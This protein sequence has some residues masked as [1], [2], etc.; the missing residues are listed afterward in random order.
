MTTTQFWLNVSTSFTAS[1]I[2]LFV[3]LIL[4]KPKILISPNIC[5]G[6]LNDSD[7]NEY[8]FIKIINYSLF[9][10]FDVKAELIQNETYTS[11]KKQLNTRNTSLSL[12][13]GQVSHIPGY[14]PSWLRKNAPYAIRVRTIDALE[15]ILNDDH[16]SVII[17]VSLRHGLTGLAKVKTRE[18][19]DISH[20]KKGRFKYGLTFGVLN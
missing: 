11:E 8:Y 14:R 16:K 9:N 1:F 10:A 19:S 7:P 4:F 3:L 6:K 17:K 2:F 20:L 18:Y 12:V 13:V 15:P 5:K